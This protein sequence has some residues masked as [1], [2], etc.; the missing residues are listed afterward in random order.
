MGC[1]S[2]IRGNFSTTHEN[3]K[4]QSPHSK[5]QYKMP[6]TF[7][8]WKYWII[9]EL[10]SKLGENNDHH[11][12][13]KSRISAEVKKNRF[14]LTLYLTMKVLQSGNKWSIHK[15]KTT[16]PLGSIFSY[17]DQQCWH[18]LT[19]QYCLRAAKDDINES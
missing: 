1:T 9:R 10:R 6:I 5:L 8:V 11:Q 15:R 14:D 3:F 17:N 4:L 2:K 13:P 12:N 16:Y 18:L 19:Y 7:P